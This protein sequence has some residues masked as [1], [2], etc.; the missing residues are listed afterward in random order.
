M[1]GCDPIFDYSKDVAPVIE[2]QWKDPNVGPH[3][4]QLITEAGDCDII[5]PIG[6][7][8]LIPT[9]LK[10]LRK[11]SGMELAEMPKKE[12]MAAVANGAVWTYDAR[13][14]RMLP[15]ALSL[16][17]QIGT[18]TKRKKVLSAFQPLSASSTFNQLYSPAEE[19]LSL[20]LVTEK[21]GQEIEIARNEMRSPASGEIRVQTSVSEGST[22]RLTASSTGG[23]AQT[24]WEVTL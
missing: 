23:A 17:I 14:E 3:L 16:H 15:M 7:T 6:G 12:R 22:F 13:M 2:E 10:E 24:L 21:D 19:T 11:W 1:A 8:T 18:Q 20:T 4:Q 5:V 9:F